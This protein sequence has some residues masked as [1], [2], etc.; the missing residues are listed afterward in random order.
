MIFFADFGRL[1]FR[2][3]PFTNV[4][5]VVILSFSFFLFFFTSSLILSIKEAD[6]KCFVFVFFRGIFSFKFMHWIN[7][8]N[9]CFAVFNSLEMNTINW[10]L[11]FA[12]N[13]LFLSPY[14]FIFLSHKMFWFKLNSDHDRSC[15]CYL[16]TD[17]SMLSMLK[18]GCR[19]AQL[20]HL[21]DYYFK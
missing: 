1:F 5:S 18:C 10:K 8:Y 2:C 4:D 16:S 15:R 19:F 17:S 9:R 21:S 11:F 3:T 13:L 14:L 20:H 12:T 7:Q 6:K